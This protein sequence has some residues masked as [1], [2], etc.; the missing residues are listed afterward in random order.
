MILGG[1]RS[2]LVQHSTRWNN[3][4]AVKRAH[5]VIVARRNWAFG[6][7]YGRV[8]CSAAPVP[9]ATFVSPC[10]FRTRVQQILLEGLAEEGSR[11]T[12]RSFFDGR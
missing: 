8:E 3:R 10:E 5:A 6:N 4:A 2:A 1:N 7:L 12:A 11:A 9:S